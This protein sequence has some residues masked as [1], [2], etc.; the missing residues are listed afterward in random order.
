MSFRRIPLAAAALLIAAPLAAEDL[1]ILSKVSFARSETTSTQ[2]ITAEFSRSSSNDTDSI[3]HFPSG[4]LTLV[5]H[6]KKEYWEMTAEEMEDYWYKMAR[7]M[8]TSGAAD[9]FD[10]RGESKLEKLPGKQKVAGYDCEHWSLQ[11]GDALEM[12]LWTTPALHVPARYFDGRR[13]ATTAMGPLGLLFQRMYEELKSVKGFPLSTVTIIRTPFSRTETN[14]EAV[15][16]K[17]GP[18]PASTF[19]I[20]SGYTKTKPPFVK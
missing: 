8:R 11:V 20:P 9:V 12:E 2:Y 3:V 18:I 1:T 7:K 14:D 10:L 4:K 19:A 17:K 13:L 16:V 5:D 15:E 6:R